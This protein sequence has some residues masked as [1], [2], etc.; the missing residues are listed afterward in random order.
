MS[1]TT[2]G[3]WEFIREQKTNPRN[4]F[5]FLAEKQSSSS[6][7]P[8]WQTR[9][10][11]LTRIGTL[12]YYKNRKGHLD[13]KLRLSIFLGDV[14]STSLISNSSYNI[15][16]LAFASKL[17]RFRVRSRHKKGIE[18]LQLFIDRMKSGLS[19]I[20]CLKNVT[21]E[22]IETSQDLSVP[23]SNRKSNAAICLS[24]YVGGNCVDSTDIGVRNFGLRSSRK[25]LRDSRPVI[26][27]PDSHLTIQAV[28]HVNGT[29]RIKAKDL[30]DDEHLAGEI[31]V[32]LKDKD[33][34]NAGRAF[35]R[36]WVLDE[37]GRASLPT[38]FQQGSFLPQRSHSLSSS[39]SRSTSRPPPHPHYA[40]SKDS[41]HGRF[42]RA[43]RG[44]VRS[45]RAS[46]LP[47]AFSMPRPSSSNDNSLTGFQK[48]FS[49]N[50]LFGIR[51]LS[52][53]SSRPD[54][55]NSQSGPTNPLL[56]R[57]KPQLS[58]NLHL[59]D[60]VLHTQEGNGQNSMSSSLHSFRSVKISDFIV[61]LLLLAALYNT[62][63]NDMGML[64]ILTAALLITLRDPMSYIYPQQLATL[65]SEVTEHGSGIHSRQQITSNPIVPEGRNERRAD[66]ISG[67]GTVTTRTSATSQGI[68]KF[69]SSLANRATELS[70]SLPHD[71]AA[72]GSDKA[73]HNSFLVAS[74][75]SMSSSLP[76]QPPS[77]SI[78]RAP[79]A[80]ADISSV[81][82]SSSVSG[83][84]GMTKN[85]FR[86]F[87][88][89]NGEGRPLVQVVRLVEFHA[90]IHGSQ[91]ILN[92]D[93]RPRRRRSLPLSNDRIWKK[94]PNKP[95][96]HDVVL[97]RG[98]MDGPREEN[99]EG[100]KAENFA[101]TEHVFP[102]QR[103]PIWSTALACAQLHIHGMPCEVRY[104]ILD[105]WH[106]EMETFTHYE[107]D[108]NITEGKESKCISEFQK[109]LSQMSAEYEGEPFMAWLRNLQTS[110]TDTC[111]FL[112][113]RDFDVQKAVKLVKQAIDI[114][115]EYKLD[116]ILLTPMKSYERCKQYLPMYHQGF[117][118]AGRMICIRHMGK[119]NAKKLL[120]YL[121]LEDFVKIELMMN[122]IHS[123]IIV[124]ANSRVIRRQE[125][126]SHPIINMAGAGI[127]T[128]LD[129]DFRQTFSASAAAAQVCYPE[130]LGRAS[131]V[132]APLTFSFL[133]SVLKN[134][135]TKRTQN[136]VVVDSSSDPSKV[137]L[138]FF[139]QTK[140]LPTDFGGSNKNEGPLFL[141]SE[142][143]MMI[144][145]YIS[146]KRDIREILPDK[147]SYI[148]IPYAS[149]SQH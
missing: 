72:P 4:Y 67:A 131:I 87:V 135:T 90:D 132:R 65:R 88:Q 100:L 147:S 55:G 91:E 70:S 92:K 37:V 8:K 19:T 139:E 74:V 124:P 145:T 83:S 133:W 16:E 134:V 38:D 36:H 109:I 137:L 116:E 28:G 42:R 113:A 89:S 141:N 57:S 35:L 99:V 63:R 85:L 18:S 60:P 10:F 48:T 66:G 86:S 61:P 118:D 120:E 52:N 146:G 9:F 64:F 94:E 128:F 108:M 24:L 103:L 49:S 115:K 15:L 39:N 41:K 122:E 43:D 107:P 111:R 123:R 45:I 6:W 93:A 56:I 101:K 51:N 77:R 40:E 84:S 50:D 21:Q 62:G 96:S 125:W 121:T 136:K 47:R 102:E 13:G 32:D 27:H 3:K 117:D 79:S 33:N 46:S 110:L 112:M 127:S 106:G 75:N 29:A 68:M 71:S 69:G 129:K 130:V 7:K 26:V 82:G 59:Q 1:R 58:T 76:S 2:P 142:L 78:S 54:I 73:L 5:E 119:M 97:N 17:R 148:Y 20:D 105:Y 95:D 80:P 23:L 140:C 144:F 22:D 12:E 114:R 11:A 104:L 44:V 14:V 53:S 81:V 143:E 126:R 34:C 25:V 149:P 31:C 98:H 30:L 138:P